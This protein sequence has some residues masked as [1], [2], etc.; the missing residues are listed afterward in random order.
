M[1]TIHMAI[2]SNK[3]SM[4]IAPKPKIKKT[5][6]IK[7]FE[8]VGRRKEAVARVRLY[9][10]NKEKTA[11]VFEKKIKR[12][13]IIINKKSIS[14]YFPSQAEKNLYLLPLTLTNSEDRFA[15]SILTR[16]GGHIGTL[17]A[18]VHGLARALEKVDRETYRPI[19][20]KAGLLKRDSR[21]RERRKVGTGGKA[22]RAKQSPK[23]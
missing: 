19:L 15:I 10:T 11:N 14:D 20:K 12:G 17:E 2:N 18:I 5:K 23:R 6:D 22:R 3:I 21:E 9:L 8:G 4:D 16:G 7:Y 13:E 1:K